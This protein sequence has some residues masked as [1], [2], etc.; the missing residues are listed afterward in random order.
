VTTRNIYVPLNHSDGSNPTISP[1]SP[2]NDILIY[3]LNESVLYPNAN[4]Y[5]ECMIK[6]VFCETK[7][8]RIIGDHGY[9]V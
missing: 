3:R 8:G 7:A 9:I 6:Q 2:G 5:M 4:C 1:A